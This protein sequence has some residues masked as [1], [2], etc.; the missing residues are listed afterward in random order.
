MLSDKLFEWAIYILL[1][2]WIFGWIALLIG[3][4]IEKVFPATDYKI[5]T[6]FKNYGNILSKIQ[7]MILI[8]A[9]TL[10]AIRFIAGLLGWASPLG[11]IFYENF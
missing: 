7:K 1:G 5:E 2:I 6:L 8:F 3:M 11:Q 10:F 9:I 4:I